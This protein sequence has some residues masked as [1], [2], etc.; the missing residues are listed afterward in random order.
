MTSPIKVRIGAVCWCA[1][2]YFTV[3]SLAHGHWTVAL[4]LLAALVLMP[5]TW[6]LARDLDDTGWAA[7][8]W[9]FD[10]HLQLPAALLLIPAFLL[11]VGPGAML[12]A[13][14]WALLL[15]VM[16]VDGLIRI[17]R[18]GFAPLGVFCRDMGLVYASI[19]GVWLL[20]NRCG[21]SPLGFAPHIV[22]LT[23]VHFHYAGL[24]L[25]VVASLV[26]ARR[27]T[28]PLAMV[29]SVMVLFG[30]PLVAISIL[31]SSRGGPAWFESVAAWILAL[32]GL[33]VAVQHIVL[34]VLERSVRPVVRGLWFIAGVALAIGMVLAALYSSRTYLDP[35]PWLD[36]P[37]MRMVHGSLNSLGFA[38]AALLAWCRAGRKCCCGN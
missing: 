19:G 3:A 21:W 29:S 38:L 28:C 37:W 4:L 5:M 23:A 2:I 12:C 24:I 32:G 36:V 15:V 13:L 33:G 27:S 34:A 7:R 22:L 20:A 14:P 16:G 9:K 10:L 25:P 11:P 35:L 8:L 26:L 31:L 30:V 6:C 18:H 1:F 17:R